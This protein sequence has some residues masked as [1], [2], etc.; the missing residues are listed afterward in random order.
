MYYGWT[1]ARV[2]ELKGYF[3]DGLSASQI[4]GELGGLTRNAVIGKLHRLKLT[5]GDR[6]TLRKSN[7]RA[8]SQRPRDIVRAAVAL[9]ELLPE[10]CDLPPDQSNHAVDIH[11]LA[12][13]SC[14]WPLGE[15]S[16]LM[17]YCGDEA[18]GHVYCPRHARLA[19]APRATS[20]PYVPKAVRAA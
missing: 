4:A 2:E 6:A 18:Q 19:Y 13:H 3:A 15:P 17:M 1:N 5:A 11:D 9:N 14:R 12:E 8:D 16:H 10:M 7:R 20:Q